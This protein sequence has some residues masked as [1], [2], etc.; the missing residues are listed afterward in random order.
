M[1]A[2]FSEV[3]I[4]LLS[5]VACM[6][7]KRQKVKSDYRG[8]RL[9]EWSGAWIALVF[10]SL[11]SLIF[12]GA[13]IPF[14]STLLFFLLTTNGM[15]AAYSVLFHPF[16]LRIYEANVFQER[17]TILDYVFKYIAIYFSGIN[18]Y[19]QLT[20]LKLPLLLNKLLAIVFVLLLAGLALISGLIYN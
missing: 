4:L 15:A 3:F 16:A 10:S 14:P 13:N 9:K 19:V 5:F 1:F 11:F 18:Y 2:V 17:E 6:R 20:L 7:S 8:Q 12:L